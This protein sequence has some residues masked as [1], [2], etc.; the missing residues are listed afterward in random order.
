MEQL[1]H[2][3][4]RNH[5]SFLYL[6]PERFY[7]VAF[8][9]ILRQ[10]VSDGHVARFVIDEVQTVLEVCPWNYGCRRAVIEMT[11]RSGARHLSHR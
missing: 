5:P 11:D 8:Q 4:S 1:Q 7:Q 2:P 6:T 3:E 10:R 9:G